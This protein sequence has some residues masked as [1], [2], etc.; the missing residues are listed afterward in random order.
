MCIRGWERGWVLFGCLCGSKDHVVSVW[1]EGS[2]KAGVFWR[3]CG[4][5]GEYVVNV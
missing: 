3:M 2:V 1:E 5:C 4:D